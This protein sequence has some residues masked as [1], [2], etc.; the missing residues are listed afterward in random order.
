MSAASRRLEIRRGAWVASDELRSTR[1]GVEIIAPTDHSEEYMHLDVAGRLV[2]RVSGSRSYLAKL[3]GPV[4]RV[5]AFSGWFFALRALEKVIE[6]ELL[7][8]RHWSEVSATDPRVR[9]LLPLVRLPTFERGDAEVQLGPNDEV[10]R[11][12][13]LVCCTYN[14]VDELLETLPTLVR[15]AK[16]ARATGIPCRVLVV[17]Q[18]PETPARVLEKKPSLKR[19]VEFIPS[20]PPGLTRARNVGLA[21]STADLVIFV[22]DDVL[23]DPGFVLEH[24]RAA[25]HFPRAVGVAGRIKSRGEGDRIVHNRAVG[26][27]RPTGY[28]DTWFDSDFDGVPLVPLTPRGANMAFRRRRVNALLG[29]KWFD[30]SLDG[31]A[32]REETTVALELFRR[33]SFL[34]YAPHASLYHFESLSGGCENRVVEDDA[35]LSKRLSL[36]YL[37]LN[38]LYS[39]DGLLRTLGPLGLL[40]RDVFKGDPDRARKALLS[41]HARGYR[42]GRERFTRSLQK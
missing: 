34:V 11:T 18:N 1:D 37:F 16:R 7:F 30:E 17:H 29:P 5:R 27:L 20:L 23:L 6:L 41:L 31:S 2:H 8:G 36:E 14:R 32:H 33:G 4:S 24:V 39:H 38:R 15:E 40:A 25:E 22:D 12:A 3:L 19:A 26:Q 21:H 42:D 35:R 9:M 10:V 13:D 28:V